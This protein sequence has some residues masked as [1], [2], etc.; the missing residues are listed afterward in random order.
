MDN[1][2]ISLPTLIT[3]SVSP[4]GKTRKILVEMTD[5]SRVEAVLMEQHYGYSV[6]V[7]SQVGCA[8]GCVFCA[9]T[10]KAVC[11]DDL[12]VAEIIGQVVIFGALTKEQIHSVVVMGAGE[13]LQNYDN[14]LQALQ[15]LLRS[16]NL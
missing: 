6:C 7:S 5:Q 11:T 3:E 1:C 12:T 9:S 13:P 14:V 10:H 8:M 4:D 2:I 16:C 15:L